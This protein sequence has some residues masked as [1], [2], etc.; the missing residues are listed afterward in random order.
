[1]SLSDFIEKYNIPINS[2]DNIFN[3]INQISRSSMD[4]RFSK[5]STKEEIMALNKEYIRKAI[6]LILTK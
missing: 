3:D 1:M 4:I 6:S 5:Y 2:T